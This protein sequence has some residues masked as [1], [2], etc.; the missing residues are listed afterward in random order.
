MQVFRAF[1]LAVAI[2]PIAS[3]A[4][5]GGLYASNR[6]IQL[7]ETRTE[8][9]NESQILELISHQ[10][11]FRDITDARPQTI[12]ISLS[13]QPTFPTTLTH[14]AQVQ[15]L[16]MQ[17]SET[18]PRSVLTNFTTFTNRYYNNN[19]GKRSSAWLLDTI[20]SI[21]SSRVN[22]TTFAHRFPQSSIIA[23]INGTSHN[24]EVVIISAHQDSIN[25]NNPDTGRAPGADDDGSGTVT[26]LEALRVFSKSS[27]VSKRAVEFHWYAGEEGGLL[28]SADIAKQYT[29]DGRAIVAD[30]HFDMTGYPT[31]PPVV[32][33]VTDYT[34]DN[35]SGLVRQIVGAYT[36]LST[37]D[38][39]CGYACSDHA[40]WTANGVRAA[41]PFENQY[42]D[43]NNNIHTTR[44]TLGT[45]DFGHLV[46][47]VNIAL[48][49]IV[50][51]SDA[52]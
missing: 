42:V 20:K 48:G 38:F 31:S 49:F 43:G 12:P 24:D 50:E 29:S 41:L 52:Q 13:S 6:L 15:P 25:G 21:A 33:I 45:V 51:V 3:N 30:L 18:V 28:G 5:T 10:Q 1:L 37:V 22:V 32:G 19:N 47:F 46:K 17:V 35:A 9:M 7:S 14:Q 26:I 11:R 27:L 8:W 39:T 36:D 44:D 16:L 4:A 2:L 23:R 34:D 40:S